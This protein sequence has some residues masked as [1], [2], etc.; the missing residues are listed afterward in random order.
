VLFPEYSDQAAHFSG[1][2]KNRVNVFLFDL[3]VM[4][5]HEQAKYFDSAAYYF[6]RKVHQGIHS[7]LDLLQYGD[8]PAEHAVLA[9]QDFYCGCSVSRGL[10]GFRASRQDSGA[11]CSGQGDEASARKRAFEKHRLSWEKMTG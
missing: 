2:V 9:G 5:H 1:R 4:I 7:A 10:I 11:C 8:G 3:L 6:G